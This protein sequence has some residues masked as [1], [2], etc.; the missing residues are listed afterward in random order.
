MENQTKFWIHKSYSFSL[1]RDNF[2]TLY[3]DFHV[4]EHNP[5]VCNH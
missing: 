5:K 2:T 3:I 1:F 4:A